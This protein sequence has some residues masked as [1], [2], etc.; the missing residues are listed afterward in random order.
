MGR[1]SGMGSL[2][3]QGMHYKT[4]YHKQVLLLF[5]SLMFCL[6]SVFKLTVKKHYNYVARLCVE[7]K[8][9]G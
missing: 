9:K 8:S 4:F 1:M 2:Q 5:K 7:R 6:N 3:W